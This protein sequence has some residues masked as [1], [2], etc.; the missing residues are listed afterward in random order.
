M[1]EKGFPGDRLRKIGRRSG[2]L[3]FLGIFPCP[4]RLT[5]FF[6]SFTQGL[7]KEE[8][9]FFRNNNKDRRACGRSLQAI[10]ENG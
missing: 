5:N 7:K 4:D 9:N 2:I 1:D 10:N 8:E 6:I 3:C